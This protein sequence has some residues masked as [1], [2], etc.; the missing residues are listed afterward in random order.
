[1]WA[2]R[3]Q[4]TALHCTAL[5]CTALHCT[6]RHRTT[7]HHTALHCTELHCTT[8][9]CTSLHCTAVH[10]TALHSTL[11]PAPKEPSPVS[12]HHHGSSRKTF[13]SWVLLGSYKRVFPKMAHLVLGDPGKT[14]LRTDRDNEMIPTPVPG[15]C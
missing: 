15:F 10:L 9:H 11:G 5:H 2:A 7:P 6:A 1:M 13:M 8:L 3:P 12:F 4:T 14:F